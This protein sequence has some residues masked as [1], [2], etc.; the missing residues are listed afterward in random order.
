MK[1]FRELIK[2][3]RMTPGI[4]DKLEPGAPADI[5]YLS[6]NFAELV[7]Q[8]QPI[9]LDRK[10]KSERL[11]NLKYR[12]FPIVSAPFSVFSLEISSGESLGLMRSDD[13]S[14]EWDVLALMAYEVAPGVFHTIYTRR[15]GYEFGIGFSTQFHQ[16]LA[17]YVGK[18][19]TESV[20]VERTNQ[21]VNVAPNGKTR[22]H[23][24]NRI[25]HVRPRSVTQNANSV[26]R[27]IDW[28]HAWLVRGH[29]RKTSGLGKDRAGDY[30]VQ[31]MTWVNEHRKGPDDAVV[32]PKVRLVHAAPE[33]KP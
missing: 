3:I 5:R 25:I 15:T 12:D 2:T 21:Q 8:S 22:L 23:T 29:W 1:G 20:G 4:V 6:R 26:S 7:A 9:V 14:G 11:S 13:L 32:V 33:V 10:L 18:L 30:C 27:K 19:S 24:F 17:E 28:S 31:G 16:I